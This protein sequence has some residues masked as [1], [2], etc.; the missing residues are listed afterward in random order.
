MRRGQVGEMKLGA[1]VRREPEPAGEDRQR[2]TGNDLARTQ[3]DREKR[4]NR[5]HRSPRRG[6]PDHGR[7]EDERL[8]AVDGL[9]DPEPD[10]RPE[11]HHPLDAEIEHAGSLREQFAERR[12]EE[13]CPVQHCLGQHEHEQAVVDAHAVDSD[14][15]PPGR[16]SRAKRTR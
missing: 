9:R 11:Q 8:R 1:E 5:R 10:R 3:R 7:R 14:G 16:R 13:R 6:S 12:V 15:L 4:V 2:Q